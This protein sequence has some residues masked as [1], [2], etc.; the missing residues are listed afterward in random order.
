MMHRPSSAAP[1]S[2]RGMERF[3]SSATTGKPSP[4]RIFSQ[5]MAD[6]N[7]DSPFPRPS[8]HSGSSAGTDQAGTPRLRRRA[9]EYEAENTPS[10]TPSRSDAVA[11]R[12][13][14]ARRS[15][16]SRSSFP[17]SAGPAWTRDGTRAAPAPARRVRVCAAR[18][19]CS[20]SGTTNVFVFQNRQRKPRCLRCCAAFRRTGD[21]RYRAG[22][23]RHSAA[24]PARPRQRPLQPL[25][26]RASAWHLRLLTSSGAVRAG[27]PVRCS[28]R[29]P[30]PVVRRVS[31]AC[32][33][34]PAARRGLQGTRGA[35]RCPA[36]PTC[37]RAVR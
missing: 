17:V 12:R 3:I 37:R 15:Q 10:A 29:C 24:D 2:R 9:A 27:G 33:A 25:G 26:G 28:S 36:R 22:R 35:H 6:A 30:P 19:R 23:R 7:P 32:C 11:V 13:P 14:R 4:A 31:R 1:D 21:P 8:A 34:D 16:G 20:A 18:R 5:A